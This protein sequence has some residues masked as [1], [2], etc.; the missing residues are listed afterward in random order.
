MTIDAY[1]RDG[2]DADHDIRFHEETPTG[3]I[4]SRFAANT[5]ENPGMI[6]ALSSLTE[7]CKEI[8]RLD[9]FS[10]RKIEW[11]RPA[12]VRETLIK[13]TG[14]GPTSSFEPMKIELPKFG[15]REAFDEDK[16]LVHIAYHCYDW[17]KDTI[18]QLE[19]ALSGYVRHGSGQLELAFQREAGEPI[20][21]E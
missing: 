21:A 17:T 11:S 3:I 1:I 18:R 4:Y 15:Y 13:I 14:T 19:E 5:E 9:G 10:I 7:F 20:T 16:N 8:S 6:D 2:N 12:G